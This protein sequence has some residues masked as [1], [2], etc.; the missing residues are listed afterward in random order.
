[1]AVDLSTKDRGVLL[2]KIDHWPE[3]F[4]CKAALV[5]K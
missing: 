2:R 1:M 5:Q 3:W 4:A